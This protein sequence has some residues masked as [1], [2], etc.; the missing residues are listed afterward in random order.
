MT[1]PSR[2]RPSARRSQWFSH[3]ALLA[4]FS[5]G[6]VRGQEVPLYALPSAEPQAPARDMTGDA[7]QPTDRVVGGRPAAHAAWPSLVVVRSIDRQQGTMSTCGGTVIAPDWVL[8]AAHCAQGR[9]ASSFVVVEGT[10]N[11]GRNGREIGVADVVVHGD[12]SDRPYPHNDVALLRLARPATSAP[13]VLA[14]N[15]AADVL[16]RDG[17]AAWVAGFGLT[18]A[19]P[20]SGSHTGPASD[21]LL[22]TELPLVERGACTRIIDGALKSDRMG[23]LVDD[24]T[25][26][27]GD[28]RGGRD[29]CN[30]DSGGPLD[31]SI[32]GGRKVQLGVVSWGPGCA[33][34]DTVGVY[35]SVGHFEPWIRQRVPDATFY[36]LAAPAAPP[37][38]AVAS[39]PASAP[40]TAV[41]A[42][43]AAIGDHGGLKVAL[44]NGRAVK[45]GQDIQVKVVST[46]P[47][48]LLVYNLDLETGAAYQVFPNRY[49]AAAV[50]GRPQL[51]VRAGDDVLVPGPADRFLIEA[52]APLGHN[53][54][55]AFVLPSRVKVE[56]LAARGLD[57]HDL[58]DPKAVFGEIADRAVAVVPIGAAPDRAVAVFDYDIEN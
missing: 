7:E 56:D 20:V 51:A 37:R 8:T 44:V 23:G 42:A 1:A 21:Q 39:V 31:V 40:V 50:A 14:S 29:S 4:L 55:Y 52:R 9:P 19:Q 27:A 45:V 10:S 46:I 33:L 16:Y 48:Q 3:V 17:T 5:A 36:V 15:Q 32:D 53:R 58:A 13:Q 26:C 25:I 18:H 34:R 57:M 24:A 35:A 47:G 12:Y 22:Q 28:A 49:S 54:I 2:K 43:A 6:G 38:P 11:L 41:E 30:G